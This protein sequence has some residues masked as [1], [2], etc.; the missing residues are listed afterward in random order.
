MGGGGGR[1]GGA[2]EVRWWRRWPGRAGRA[3][4]YS[5][6][7]AEPLSLALSGSLA[8]WLAPRS[9]TARRPALA[10][11]TRGG[12]RRPGAAPPTAHARRASVCMCARARAAWSRSA[13][14]GDARRAS[15]GPLRSAAQ[16]WTRRLGG[17]CEPRQ[18]PRAAV[19]ERPWRCPAQEEAG[20]GGSFSSAA[21]FFFLPFPLLPPPSFFSSSPSARGAGPPP[22]PTFLHPLT[23]L[24]S[25]FPLSGMEVVPRRNPA[26]SAPHPHPH[27]TL[28]GTEVAP[29]LATWTH[30]HLGVGGLLAFYQPLSRLTFHLTKM[31]F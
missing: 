16:S 6:L 4:R 31:S 22:L 28:A 29:C 15:L 7:G 9:L 8:R 21:R 11:P 23:L 3:L 14:D 10:L 25:C 19:G 5:E 13:R 17:P 30:R 2:D 27:A 24:C 12:K 18:L 26:R 1:G 20:R